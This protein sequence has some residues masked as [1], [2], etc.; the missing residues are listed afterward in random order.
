MTEALLLF[1]E[2]HI[3]PT[4]M[5]CHRTDKYVLEP[6]VMSP[7]VVGSSLGK[8][9][10]REGREEPRLYHPLRESTNYPHWEVYVCVCVHV[11]VCVC[12]R[13]FV[14]TLIDKTRR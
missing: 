12:A 6:C 14:L 3:N 10:E 9:R 13:V 7:A 4:H 11:C 8:V 5:G 2:K 1:V